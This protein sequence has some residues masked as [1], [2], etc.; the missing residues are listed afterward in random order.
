[1]SGALSLV[2]LFFGVGVG[3]GDDLLEDMIC[4]GCIAGVFLGDNL[5]KM[6]TT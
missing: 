1:M 5:E 2:V 3:V 6:S 4:L